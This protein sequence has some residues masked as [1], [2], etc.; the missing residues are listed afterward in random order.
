[1]AT[2]NE[3][4]HLIAERLPGLSPGLPPDPVLLR[5]LVP[6]VLYWRAVLL[7]REF[8][9]NGTYPKAARQE[10]VVPLDVVDVSE[11]ADFTYGCTVYRTVN[12]VPQPVRTKDAPDFV[13]VGGVDRQ[14]PFT[15]CL[16]EEAVYR[17]SNRYT[18]NTPAYAYEN[19]Y[20]YV[21]NTSPERLLVQ[22]IF[23]DP[24]QVVLYGSTTPL[25]E[26]DLDQQFPLPEDIV[27]ALVQAVLTTEYRSA[28]A[29]LPTPGNTAE[30][31]K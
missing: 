3:I 31:S 21:F 23:Q 17:A 25:D 8:S 4:V 12:P 11:L 29:Q 10:L 19:G 24:R 1:M 6:T 13:Y 22:G 15:Y 2:L 7:R 27:Q 26:Y 28:A 20:V 5:T 18:K 9:T 16:R 30:V 14:H